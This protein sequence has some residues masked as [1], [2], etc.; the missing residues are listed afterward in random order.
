MNLVLA[1]VGPLSFG[2]VVGWITYRTL[3]RSPKTGISDLASVIAAVGG[4]GVT[5]LIGKDQNAF[6]VY[7]VGLGFGF[8][9]YAFIA[10][11]NPNL[12]W[13][14]DDEVRVPQPKKNGPYG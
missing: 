5:A 10:A 7:C 12:A 14:G 3:R 11:R 1:Y 8:F 6:N 2:L 4:A 13:L 9:G